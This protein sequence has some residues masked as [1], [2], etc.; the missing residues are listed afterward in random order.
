[1]SLSER[2]TLSWFTLE[3]YAL[4][5]LSEAERNEV[6]A[7]LQGSAFNRRRLEQNPGGPQ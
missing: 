6:E 5:E 4:G 3:R 2:R 7:E 1:M